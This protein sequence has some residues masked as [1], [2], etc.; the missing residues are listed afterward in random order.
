MKKIYT[1]LILAITCHTFTFA[2][3]QYTGFTM[4]NYAGYP[5]VYYQPAAIVNTNHK[6]NF[7]MSYVLLNTS[8]YLAYNF[9]IFAGSIDEQATKYSN[10]S[11]LGYQSF[12][13]S[14]DLFGLSYEINH[15]NAIGYSLRLRYFSNKEGIPQAYTEADYNDYIDNGVVGA[16][17]EIKRMNYQNFRYLEHLFNY[18]RVIVDD[19]DRFIKAGIGFKIIN[20]F[21]AEYFYA[22][23]EMQFN[24]ANSSDASFNNTSFQF[25]QANNSSS[26]DD[27]N[28]GF[29]FDLGV[30]YEY[31]PDHEK[32]YYDM[33]GVKHIARYDKPKYKYK[34]GISLTDLGFVRFNKDTTTYNFT[35]NANFNANS[36]MS[37]TSDPY[38]YIKNTVQSD[39]TS[40]ATGDDKEKFTM[41]LPTSLNIQFDYRLLERIFASY[42][43]AFSIKLPGDANKV[44]QKAIHTVTPRFESNQY[45]LLLPITMQ[46]NGQFNVGLGGRVTQNDALSFYAG[47]NN[48]TFLFGKRTIYTQNFYMGFSYNIPYL[49]PKDTDGDKVSDPFDECVY[50]PGLLELKGCPDTDGDGIPDKEDY[51]VYDAG[52]KHTFGCP[53]KDG[54]GV[55]DLNDQC[56]DEAGLAVHY[57]CPDTDKDGVIDVADQCPD[58]PGVE[59]NNGCPFEIKNCCQDDD[60]DTVPNSIDKCPN[61]Q[62]SV[63]NDGCPVNKDNINDIELTDEKADKDPNH[64]ENQM[65][66]VKENNP[67]K[68]ELTPEETQMVEDKSDINDDLSTQ[69]LEHSSATLNVYYETDDATIEDE[70]Q[71]DIT[72]LVDTYGNDVTYVIIGHTDNQGSEDY[73]LILSRKRAEVLK[74]TLINRGIDPENIVVYYYGE[75]K[76]LKSNDNVEDRHYNRRVEVQVYKK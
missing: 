12:N 23:G 51:C 54:D 48:I 60:G 7:N 32:Y 24:T 6:V 72:N 25:G 31:R 70:Y 61:E 14:A 17:I 15:E 75:W 22:D 39:A 55:I 49:V 29:G 64:T 36:L 4:D 2:Q 73:N 27:R 9:N 5:G 34:L 52:P 43:G 28:N 30:V 59:L 37:A 26:L 16:P 74:R 45:S 1:L 58:V 57:G 41:N 63:Y 65:D 44:H 66:E 42:T 33:D 35:T 76:P 18:G 69:N 53:D 68:A 40:V 47:S 10:H 11:S 62:G 71:T 67:D 13:F 3:Q 38:D 50:D 19:R 20:G 56:P 21:N 46:R 8:N